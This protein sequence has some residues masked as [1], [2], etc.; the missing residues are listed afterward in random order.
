MVQSQQESSEKL[1]TALNNSTAS[2]VAMLDMKMLV[3]LAMTNFTPHFK[4]EA[5]RTNENYPA[6]HIEECVIW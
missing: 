5:M 1:C 4:E 2:L 3:D 6:S